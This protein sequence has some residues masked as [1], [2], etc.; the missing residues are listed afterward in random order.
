VQEQCRQLERQCRGIENFA[1]KELKVLSCV[2]AKSRA[3]DV[4]ARLEKLR[5]R[6]RAVRARLADRCDLFNRRLQSVA[7]P[8]AGGA[9][10]RPPSPFESLCMSKHF[11]MLCRTAN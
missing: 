8:R 1:R 2:A 4:D 5:G 7:D 9:D 6:T 10:V 3:S 11:I